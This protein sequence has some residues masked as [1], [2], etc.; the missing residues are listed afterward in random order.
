MD[1]IVKQTDTEIIAE[2]KR[3]FAEADEATA[4]NRKLMREDLDFSDPTNPQ[5][6]P[7]AVR[8]EREGSVDGARPC[9]TFDRTNQFVYQVVNDARQNKPSIKLIPQDSGSDPRMAE[10]LQGLIRQI[11]Y[12]SKA[13]VAYDTA[14]ELAARIGLGYIRIFPEAEDEETNQ[15]CIRIKRVV[16]TFSVRMDPDYTEPDGSDARWAMRYEDMPRAEFKR[17]YPKAEI[18]DFDVDGEWVTKDTVRVAE[19]FR[20]QD[21]GL[22]EHFKLTAVAVLERSEFPSQYVGLVPV[23][24]A[25]TWKDGKRHLAGLIRRAKDPQRSYNYERSSFVERVALAPK[26]P[27]IAAVEAIE[28]HEQEWGKANRANKAYLPFN[29]RD[30][31]DEPLPVP[32]RTAP[33]PMEAGW[34]GA[35]QQSLSDMQAA[36]GLFEANLGAPSNETSGK[37]ILARQR[38]GDTATFHYLDNLSLS[39]AQVG[40]IIVEMIPR[41]YDAQRVIRVLGEDESSQ[42][43]EVSPL[44]EVAYAEQ[45][46]PDGKPRI[47]INPSVGKYDVAVTTGPGYTTRRQESAAAIGELVNGN[48]QILSILGDEWVRMMDWPGADKLAQRFQAL[49]PPELKTDGDDPRLAKMGAAMEQMQA[50]AQQVVQQLQGQMAEMAAQAQQLQQQVSGLQAETA[51]KKIEL[52][53]KNRE[54]EIKA[55]DAETKRIQVTQTTANPEQVAQAAAEMVMQSLPPM[56]EP[57]A[58]QAFEV[59][60]GP[61]AWAFDY[62]A[63]G[64]IIGAREQA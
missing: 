38:E 22:C 24:G 64:N 46:G 8:R 25:E 43:V 53:I 50:Q 20:R 7:D 21:K 15:Q 35:A 9:L 62:D 4:D 11:E 42:F 30:D 54:T 39:I 56:P 32:Q 59:P 52:G 41:L 19:Y 26:A 28:G 10:V 47:T 3:R 31:N 1:V 13:S 6:W 37:A 55:F 14:L 45:A 34:Q 57:V 29:A 27:F 2:A 60:R 18:A 12:A 61:R 40:R 36:F 17:R 48:P 58:P 44:Q 33:A 51:L 49:L 63:E 16:N 23:I 5:Q